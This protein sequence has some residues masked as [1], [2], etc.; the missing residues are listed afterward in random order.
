MSTTQ[1][2]EERLEEIANDANTKLQE[3]TDRHKREIDTY[4]AELKQAKIEKLKEELRA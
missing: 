3:I 2:L 1:T 4:L